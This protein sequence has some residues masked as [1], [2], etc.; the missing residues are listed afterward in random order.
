MC[1]NPIPRTFCRFVP[2][3]KDDFAWENDK[4]AFRTYGPA[5]RADAVN[6]GF[7]CWLKRVEYPIIDKWYAQSAAGKSYHQDHGEGLD[8]YHVGSSAGCGGVAL[9]LEGKREDL[10][11]FTRYKILECSPNQSSFVLSYKD[12]VSGHSYAEDR[13]ITIQMGRRLF[14]VESRFFK[15]GKPAA[16]LPVCIG[17]ATHDGKASAFFNRAKGWIATWEELE[18]FGLGTAAVMKP[19]DIVEIKEVV[20]KEK[21]KSHLFI[22]T[23]ADQEG[24]VK[25]RAGYGWEKAG[26][27]KLKKDWMAFMDG[28]AATVSG[29]SPSEVKG[30]AKELAD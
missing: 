15:D 7:D 12:R 25:Y 10:N 9:W 24:R 20:S 18:K 4:I 26:E 3:R 14:D 28:R 6:S 2:E 27:I 16:G 22:I 13:K 21:D 23:E 29:L 30:S 19:D 5:L 8:N 17:L 1:A 11:T